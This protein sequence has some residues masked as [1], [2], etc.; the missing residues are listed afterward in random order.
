MVCSPLI[1]QQGQTWL[2]CV[3][4]RHTLWEISVAV[5]IAGAFYTDVRAGAGTVATGR[6]A[7]ALHKA[8]CAARIRFQGHSV[9]LGFPPLRRCLN[10][11]SWLGFFQYPV[12]PS[13]SGRY[14]R[15]SRHPTALNL[16]DFCPVVPDFLRDGNE[17]GA[18]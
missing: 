10:Q 18:G 3:R 14:R 6:G 1:P 8:V 12:E 4:C 13:M 11:S 2:L 17:V 7:F 16:Q 5:D 15:L 9:P